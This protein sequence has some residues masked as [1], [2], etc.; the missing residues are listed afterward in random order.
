MA[1][2]EEDRDQLRL[3]AQKTAAAVRT[4][5]EVI[6]DVLGATDERRRYHEQLSRARTAADEVMESQRT[7]SELGACLCRSRDQHSDLIAQAELLGIQDDE[8]RIEVH[9]LLAATASVKQAVTVRERGGEP[10]VV[11][12]EK[13]DGECTS[14]MPSFDRGEGLARR[15]R[16]LSEAAHQASQWNAATRAFCLRDLAARTQE[17]SLSEQ[18]SVRLVEIWE[19]EAAEGRQCIQEL[20]KLLTAEREQAAV[21]KETA[22]RRI[23]ELRHMLEAAQE[24]LREEQAARF[25]DLLVVQQ[26]TEDAKRAT[27]GRTRDAVKSAADALKSA[28]ATLGKARNER[29]Q[30]Q[31]TLQRRLKDLNRLCNELGER[32]AREGAVVASELE[33]LRKA[34]RELQRAEKGDGTPQ[35]SEERG[36]EGNEQ[37]E[38]LHRTQAVARAKPE[39]VT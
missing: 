36:G 4:Q 35:R 17:R 33:V 11:W 12:T 18:H 30:Q 34:V 23:A 29:R 37:K 20:S 39:W 27:V 31:G 25:E 38:K 16:A 9:R 26:R 21:K 7:L 24:T 14:A 22:N 6:E 2:T 32:R 28:E 5:K 10:R 3:L 19:E 13:E 8:D 15:V 1:F